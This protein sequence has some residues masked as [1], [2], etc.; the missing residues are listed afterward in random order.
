MYTE[1]RRIIKY[2]QQ[3]NE[4]ENSW[5]KGKH[6]FGVNITQDGNTGTFYAQTHVQW[7]RICRM[8]NNFSRNV[9]FKMK[10][11][12][13]GDINS[14]DSTVFVYVYENINNEPYLVWLSLFD[15]RELL[16]A[17]EGVKPS[18]A[19]QMV[20]WQMPTLEGATAD[21]LELLNNA[22]LFEVCLKLKVWGEGVHYGLL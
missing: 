1:L 16:R 11:T 15:R 9:N 7:P 12:M 5:A 20:R 2:V 8:L 19:S 21:H 14:Y 22:Q 13:D 6:I 10:Y 18:V 17:L 4:A 3:E